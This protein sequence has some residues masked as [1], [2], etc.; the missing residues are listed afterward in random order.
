MKQIKWLVTLAESK[1]I[2]FSVALLLIAVSTLVG[3]IINRDR[4]IDECQDEIRGVRLEYKRSIDSMTT[5]YILKES[6]LINT[7]IENYKIQ[8]EE[9]K[10]I[11][12][13]INRTIKRNRGVI[14]KATNKIK[15][16][17]Q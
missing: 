14:K 6:E 9:Q 3:V 16:L 15:T 5:Y 11:N 4:K 2:L 10:Q 1:P 13:T 12:N 17:T 7:I 8:L